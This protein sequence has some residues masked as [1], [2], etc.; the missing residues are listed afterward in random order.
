MDES[1]LLMFVGQIEPFPAN[2]D[3]LGGKREPERPGIDVSALD[4]TGFD[5]APD[6]LHG[7]GLRGKRPFAGANGWLLPS[8]WVGCP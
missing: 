6:L 8:G 7:F 1:F 2:G 5:T 4:L 3:Q